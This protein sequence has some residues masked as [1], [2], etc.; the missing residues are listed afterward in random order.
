MGG[1]R[2]LQKCKAP[3]CD[4]YALR[5]GWCLPHFGIALDIGAVEPKGDEVRLSD[6]SYRL[7]QSDNLPEHAPMPNILGWLGMCLE[8][9][10]W[11]KRLLVLDDE[12]RKTLND[13]REVL[14]N[15]IEQD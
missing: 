2:K 11:P 6:E 13:L 5:D 10:Y 4:E 3:N 7:L 1:K 12:E 15:A 8:K 14:G 9:G